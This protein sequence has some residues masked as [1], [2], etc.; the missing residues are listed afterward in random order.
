MA[1]RNGVEVY[2]AYPTL[3]ASP[4]EQSGPTGGAGTESSW[5]RPVH[6]LASPI[7]DCRDRVAMTELP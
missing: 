3:S 2:G 6:G 5:H 1:E 4:L 7:R